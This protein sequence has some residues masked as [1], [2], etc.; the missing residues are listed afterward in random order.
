MAARRT[1]KIVSLIVL[2]MV[3]IIIA[4]FGFVWYFT[5]GFSKDLETFYIE[6]DGAKLSDNLNG[7]YLLSNSSAEFNV[8]YIIPGQSGYRINIAPNPDNNFTFTVDD[9][10]KDWRNIGDITH[11][12]TIEKQLDSFTLKLPESFSI[13]RFVQSLYPD[14]KISVDELPDSSADYFIMM[15]SSSDGVQSVTIGFR[16]SNGVLGVTLDKGEII[17]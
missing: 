3:I 17:L 15:I 13:E 16:I 6:Y 9:N 14:N 10:P 7:V 2:V 1:N 8:K 4:I 12:F 11:A 5:N